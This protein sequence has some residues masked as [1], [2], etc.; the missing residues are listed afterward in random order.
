MG[1][2]KPR[3]SGVA[4]ACWTSAGLAT[5]LIIL[6]TPKLVIAASTGLL[7]IVPSSPLLTLCSLVKLVVL[8][9]LPRGLLVVRR[10]DLGDKRRG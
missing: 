7:L 2:R 8:P 3:L 6:A 9:A 5:W 10:A 4:L 1:L